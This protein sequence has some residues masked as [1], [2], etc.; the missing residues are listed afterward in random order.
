R[1]KVALILAAVVLALGNN[2]VPSSSGPIAR[3]DDATIDGYLDAQF[4]DIGYP[5]ASVAIVR[6]GRVEHV[7]AFG[8]ADETGRPVTV[9]TPFTIGS[10]S[11]SITAMAVL[12]LVDGGSVELDAP[13]VRYVPSFATLDRASSPRITVRQL[14][15]QTS[16]IAP[17]ALTLASTPTTLDGEIGRLASVAP[18]AAPGATF[19]YSNANYVVLGRVIETVTRTR[20]GSASPTPAARSSGRTSCPPGLSRR[21]PRTWRRR[22]R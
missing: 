19:A 17:N 13:V 22:S 8:H 14:L 9:T 1:A 6:D 18:V 7:H 11:K 16:G 12:R 20:S 2:L 21:P 3:A 15:N 10:L 4:A 5:G